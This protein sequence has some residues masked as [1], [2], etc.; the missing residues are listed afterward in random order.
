MSQHVF[1]TTVESEDSVDEA[2]ELLREMHYRDD[3]E[4][5]VGLPI[6]QMIS[7]HCTPHRQTY[8]LAL[9]L[10]ETF[11]SAFLP[12]ATIMENIYEIGKDFCVRDVKHLIEVVVY[13][14]DLVTYYSDLAWLDLSMLLVF[15][16]FGF[17]TFFLT[18]KFASKEKCAC[19]FTCTEN[20]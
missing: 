17:L 18:R 6:A 14:A 19:T 8:R 12:G 1:V 4:M 9:D 3:Q 7:A 10:M 15:H 13:Y 11:M 20:E 2:C 5:T 16:V